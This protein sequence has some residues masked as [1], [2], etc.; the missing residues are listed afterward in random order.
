[1]NKITLSQSDFDGL[2]VHHTPPPRSECTTWKTG[3]GS[4][5]LYCEW[6][7]AVR[8]VWG[9]EIR[10]IVIEEGEAAE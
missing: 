9:F 5:W 6:V 2:P 1:M 3:A 7:E 10:R 4:L 8:G